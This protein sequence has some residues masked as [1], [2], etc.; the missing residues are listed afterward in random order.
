MD[1]VD[2]HIVKHCQSHAQAFFTLA[3]VIGSFFSDFSW[4]LS[5][6]LE[7]PAAR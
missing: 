3:D 2:H 1:V 7:A 5:G 6:L 4:L